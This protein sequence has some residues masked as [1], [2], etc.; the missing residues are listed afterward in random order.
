M[1]AAVAAATPPAVPTP[2]AAVPMTP[3]TN[4]AVMTSVMTAVV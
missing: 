3:V 1:A 4:A 2:S